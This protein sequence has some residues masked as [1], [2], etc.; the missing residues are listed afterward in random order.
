MLLEQLDSHG[1][2]GGGGKGGEESLQTL[3]HAPRLTQI[4]CRYKCKTQ[5]YR[6]PGTSLVAQGFK[7]CTSTAERVQV[8]YL[9]GKLRPCILYSP[10][11]EKKQTHYDVYVKFCIS[12]FLNTALKKNLWCFKKETIELPEKHRIKSR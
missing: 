3:Y 10:A 1:G 7:L 5:N 6:T 11:K 8:Q 2:A 12:T 4:D 9:A